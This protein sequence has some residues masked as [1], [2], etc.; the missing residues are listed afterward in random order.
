M[1][2]CLLLYLLQQ[3]PAGFQ[4]ARNFWYLLSGPALQIVSL[5]NEDKALTK[6]RKRVA[7]ARYWLVLLW[8]FKDSESQ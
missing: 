7:G 4:Q 6:T 5:K 8:I 3:K 2:F 1:F